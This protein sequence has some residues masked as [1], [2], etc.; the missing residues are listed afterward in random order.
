MD[1][2]ELVS[3]ILPEGILDY[4]ELKGVKNTGIKLE[5]YLTEK[6][7]VPSEFEGKQIESK[8]FYPVREIQD[9]PLRERTVFLKVRRRRWRDKSTKEE[10]K[11]S[12]DLIAKGTKYTQE[13]AD[14]LK[15]VGR[16][17]SYRD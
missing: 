5:I 6:G 11:R 10:L 8:G 2:L 14:F 15:E 7:S 9:F 16:I 3:Y 4:F 17:G 1:A 13:F 12:W